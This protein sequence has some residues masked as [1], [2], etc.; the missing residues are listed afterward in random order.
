MKKRLLLLFIIVI[1]ICVLSAKDY[2]LY[3]KGEVDSYLIIVENGLLLSLSFEER[4]DEGL[5]LLEC[6]NRKADVIFPLS[7]ENENEIKRV[8][9]NLTFRLED[10]SSILQGVV[11]Y[12]KFL[13][14]SDFVLTFNKKLGFDIKPFLKNINKT[15]AFSFKIDNIDEKIDSKR[16]HYSLWFEQVL[17]LADRSNNYE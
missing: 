3:A 16:V 7:Q 4:D 6:F 10:N 9:D 15:K 12:S 1:N 13:L 2:I 17:A 11:D 5:K 8:L 14:K